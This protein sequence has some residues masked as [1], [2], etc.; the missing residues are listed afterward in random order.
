MFLE[1]RVAKSGIGVNVRKQYSFPETQVRFQEGKSTQA[2]IIKQTMAMQE[3]KIGMALE[4]KS[5]HDKVPRNVTIELVKQKLPKHLHELIA[6]RRQPSKVV[7][8]GDDIHN[9]KIARL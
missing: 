1:S 9:R 7:T 4:L 5:T 8:G 6:A 2:P 3:L